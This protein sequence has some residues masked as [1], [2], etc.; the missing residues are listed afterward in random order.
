M[1]YI[2]IITH[3]LFFNP[4]EKEISSIPCGRTMPKVKDLCEYYRFKVK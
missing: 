4:V 1:N 3:S 2:I